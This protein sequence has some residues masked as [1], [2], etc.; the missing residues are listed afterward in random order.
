MHCRDVAGLHTGRSPQPGLFRYCWYRV[1]IF[2]SPPIKRPRNE[3]PDDDLEVALLASIL[4]FSKRQHAD[5]EEQRRVHER[6]LDAKLF[7]QN[8]RRAAVLADGNCFYRALAL[9]TLG[10]QDHHM[11]AREA[12]VQ[13]VQQHADLY[14]P[15]EQDVISWCDRMQRSGEWG[16]HLSLQAAA[17]RLGMGIEIVTSVPE[18]PNLSFQPL[19]RGPSPHSAGIFPG[20]RLTFAYIAP[21]HYD[22]AFPAE[23]EPRV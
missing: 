23:A 21:L 14:A 4:E 15:F 11:V 20:S 2:V 18:Q 8:L 17:T 16:D 5:I 13:E 12:I 22:A 1:F 3:P 10:D 19:R 9:H 6:H 7:Q